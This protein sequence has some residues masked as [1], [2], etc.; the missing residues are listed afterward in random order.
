MKPLFLAALLLATSATARPP[1]MRGT[2]WVLVEMN[3]KPVA[4]I[5]RV[6]L[7]LGKDGRMNGASGCNRFMGGY[8]LRGG[9]MTVPGPVAG[10]MMACT[11]EAMAFE[12]AYLTQ[13]KKGGRV[14]V[15]WEGNMRITPDG[16]GQLRFRADVPAPK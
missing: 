14:R 2:E 6:T 13:L 11:P 5:P 12:D 15:S 1:E 7:T 10:T 16:G 4:P 8:E 9:S 3:G